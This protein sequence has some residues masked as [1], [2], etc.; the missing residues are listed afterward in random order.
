VI[1]DRP[2]S[3]LMRDVP[4]DLTEPFSVADVVGR[5]NEHYQRIKKTAM[6]AHVRGLTACKSHHDCTGNRITEHR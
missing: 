1:Y 2:V 5:F 6:A 4:A 3:E